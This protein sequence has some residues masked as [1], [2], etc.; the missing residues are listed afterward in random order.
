MR[1]EH[2]VCDREFCKNEHALKSSLFKERKNDG[3]GSMEDWYYQFELC[4]PCQQVLIDQIFEHVRYN[5]FTAADAL[6]L[7]NKLR[8]KFTVG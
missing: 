1:V 2:I 8:I 7:L 6:A 3:A 4:A 5:D